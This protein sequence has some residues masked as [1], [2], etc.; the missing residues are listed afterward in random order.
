MEGDVGPRDD[1]RDALGRV[2]AGAVAIGEGYP[3]GARV[4]DDVARMAAANCVAG[5]LALA[6]ALGRPD[7]RVAAGPALDALREGWAQFVAYARGFGEPGEGG[8]RALGVG[9]DGRPADLG[10]DACVADL[11][12]RER[13]AYRAV[14]AALPLGGGKAPASDE[15]LASTAVTRAMGALDVATGLGEAPLGRALMG[16]VGRATEGWAAVRDHV[17]AERGAT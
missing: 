15:S 14:L 13:A 8:L 3:G 7:L 12:G 10:H 9:R 16:L 5:G 6:D 1:A 4:S 17:A 2:L 11:D